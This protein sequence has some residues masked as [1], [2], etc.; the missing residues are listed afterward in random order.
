LCSQQQQN[1]DRR[2]LAGCADAGIKRQTQHRVTATLQHPN[3][4]HQPPRLTAASACACASLSCA[5]RE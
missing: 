4:N 1:G 2:V 5:V 3:R